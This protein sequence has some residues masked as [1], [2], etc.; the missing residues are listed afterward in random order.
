MHMVIKIFKIVYDE[1]M[2]LNFLERQIVQSVRNIAQY[3]KREF[4][5]GKQ[6]QNNYQ[7]YSTLIYRICLNIFIWI[8]L[9]MFMLC[10]PPQPS[11]VIYNSQILLLMARKVVENK[12]KSLEARYQLD[13]LNPPTE[14]LTGVKCRST[15]AVKNLGGGSPP[16]FQL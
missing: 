9:T 14:S 16:T 10:S 11:Q 3:L 13:T 1:I 6:L 5:I 4:A 7:F 12:L 15:S 8:S 2:K